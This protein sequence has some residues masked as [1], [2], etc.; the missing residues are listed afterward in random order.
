MM[1]SI[2]N[3]KRPTVTKANRPITDGN[4]KRLYGHVH[5]EE[6]NQAEALNEQVI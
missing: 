3:W 2:L 6:L 4:G 5:R 1:G